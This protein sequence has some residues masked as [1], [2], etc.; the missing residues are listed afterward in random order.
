M[1]TVLVRQG[2]LSQADLD[3]AREVIGARDTKRLGRALRDL[4]VWDEAR[5][6]EALAFTRGRSCSS[7]SLDGWRVRVRGAA[8]GAGSGGGRAP[9]QAVHGPAHPRRG[10]PG[11]GLR[12]RARGAGR[13]RPRARPARGRAAALPEHDA[14]AGR[15]LRAV[16]RGR[17]D[18]RARGAAGHA[19]HARGGGEEPVLPAVH[20]R[21]RVPPKEAAPG[22]PRPAPPP[23]PAPRPRPR[24]YP[25]RR[26]L[27]LTAPRAPRRPPRGSERA[28]AR[29]AGEVRGPED[30]DPFEVLEITPT[31]RRTRSRTR[32]SA[33]PS[34]STRTPITARP[35]SRTSRTSW[36]PSSSASARP[37]MSCATRARAP[38]TRRA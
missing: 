5:K 26:R 22:R 23:R 17:R 4:G 13:P 20:G 38:A 32:T 11:G 10:A 33:W 2:F 18:D 25:S 3:R 24:R 12:G 16:A 21:P 37:T 34:D 35:S 29:G 19:L 8:C 31:R 6:E 27:P 9:R 30:E 15:R 36:T 1:G 14:H 28:P 7:C